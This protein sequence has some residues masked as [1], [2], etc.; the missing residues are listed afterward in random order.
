[1][2]FFLNLE[3]QWKNKTHVK[4]LLD[5]NTEISDQAKILKKLKTSKIFIQVCLW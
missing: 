1:M 2:T 5:N 4:K 3:K